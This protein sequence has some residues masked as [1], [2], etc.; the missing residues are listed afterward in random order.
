MVIY[1]PVFPVNTLAMVLCMQQSYNKAPTSRKSTYISSTG[2]VY[3][4]QL[5]Q[6]IAGSIF[7][8]SCSS[9]FQ[10]NNLLTFPAKPFP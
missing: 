3:G 1:I 2:E 10:S 8:S 9:Q 4:L 7:S 5:S 6:V